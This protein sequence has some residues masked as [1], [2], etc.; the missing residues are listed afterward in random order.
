MG[1]GLGDTDQLGWIMIGLSAAALAYYFVAVLGVAVSNADTISELHIGWFPLMLFAAVNAA[2]FS[3]GCVFR[4]SQKI[5]LPGK[6][7]VRLG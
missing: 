5:T 7:R 6:G 1:R 3:V 4:L 2:R